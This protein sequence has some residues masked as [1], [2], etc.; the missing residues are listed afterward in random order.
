MGD[1]DEISL[2]DIPL[3]RIAELVAKLDVRGPRYTS[4]PTI[5]VWHSD[6]SS[7][8]F[9][10]ALDQLRQ[11][12]AP[13][14]V[15]LHLPFCRSRCLYCGC[16]SF[17]C[18]DGPRLERYVAAVQTEIRQLAPALG[19]A[20]RHEQLHLGGGTPTHLPPSLLA[21]LLDELLAAIPGTTDAQRSVEVDPRVTTAPHLEKLAERGFSRVSIGVQDLDPQVQAAVR[22]EYDLDALQDF[23]A[24][25]RSAGFTSVNI[26]LIYGLPR[27]TPSSWRHTLEAILTVDPDRLACFGYAHLPARLPHQR[28]LNEQEL[29]SPKARLEMLLGANELLT[30][31]GYQA[32]GMDHFARPS[33]ELSQAQQ[34]GRLW[35]NY[36]GYTDTPGHE[37]LG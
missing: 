14:A 13:I 10:K 19:S 31:Q 36:M 6:V 1:G 20:I 23:V 5:P 12:G 16:N 22:R 32:I 17:V 26:D 8:T 3:K 18:H 34:A 33:D 27:Q 29:P 30:T 9:T 28:K 35:R 4:Y 2:A 11:R 21:A 37:L 15:Y 24:L 25:A 7:V